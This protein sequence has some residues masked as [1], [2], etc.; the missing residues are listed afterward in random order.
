MSIQKGPWE[1]DEWGNIID[2]DGHLIQMHGTILPDP[3]VDGAGDKALSNKQLI[4]NAPDLNHI[5]GK[6]L[7][8]VD[9]PYTNDGERAQALFDMAEKMRLAY[10]KEENYNE[11]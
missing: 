8:I 4:L 1:I 9:N 11:W 3:N 5:V 2:A 10:I 6:M 7:K